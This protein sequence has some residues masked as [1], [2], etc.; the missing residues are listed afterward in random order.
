ML[1]VKMGNIFNSKCQTIVNTI[2]C[3]GVMGA[4][5]AYEFRLRYP[6]M[7][8]KYLNLCNFDNPNRIKTGNLWLYTPSNNEIQSFK[9]ILNF[10]TKNHWKFPSKIEFIEA[11]LNKFSQT[12]K[13]KGI[14]S[15]AFPLL[16]ADKGGLDKEVVL[17]LMKKKLEKLDLDVEIW[18]FDRFAN[19]DLYD[20]FKNKFQSIELKELKKIAKNLGFKGIKFA[21]IQKALDDENI[22]SMSGMLRT[23]GLGDKTLE[24]CFRLVMSGNVLTQKSLF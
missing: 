3:V 21:S 15:I 13:D 14:T 24:A 19:D 12:Y 20:D 22:K 7:Y 5:I 10:P 23:N 4:G 16:G 2:N 8:E 6:N 9:Q 18:E 11:G 1:K 17:N